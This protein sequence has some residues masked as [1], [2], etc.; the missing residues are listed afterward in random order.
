MQQQAL[1]V[2]VAWVRLERAMEVFHAELK[3]R[4]GITGL[5]LQVLRI[6]AERPQ[7]PLAALRKAL[8]MHPATLGQ[9]I[10]ELR[11]MELVTV[12]TD[13]RDRRA[14]LVGLTEKGTALLA[15]TPLAGPG[16]LREVDHDAARLDRL[17]AALEDAVDLFGLG[18]WSP[19]RR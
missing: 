14:R 17:K 3:K 7:L 6:C 10:D 13:P 8:V 19:S 11:R 12:K 1:S 18:E 5:Q 16:R 9:S 4:F 15:E 2:I